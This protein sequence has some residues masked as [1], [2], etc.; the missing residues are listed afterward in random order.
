M[1]VEKD[2]V[3]AGAVPAVYDAYLVP[4]IFQSYAIDTAKRLSEHP[5]ASVLEI[6]CGTGVLTRA[7]A[8]TLP[9]TSRIIASDLNQ[10]MLDHAQSR[11]S[12]ENIDW[13]Q[14]DGMK[15]P[16]GD[17]EFDAVVCQFTA[18]FFP[19]KPA[20]FG[21][22]HRVLSPGGTYICSV[23]DRIEENEIADAVTDALATVFPDD[24]P[25]FMART[26]HGYHDLDVI[27]SDLARAG[28]SDAQIETIAYRSRADSPRDAAIAYCHGSPLRDE[29]IARNPSGL[30]EATNA[31]EQ[32]VA[33]RFGTGA[34]DAKM[35]AHIITVQK[36]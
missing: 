7:L 18:M 2:T 13:R 28:I 10:P 25:R 17:G 1:T 30:N 31:A 15:L 6:G 34:V 3:F 14:A 33:A 8:S 35:Q 29:I 21:E 11:L 4:L 19:D 24:P 23:W 5:P 26:P 12:A 9:S 20:A 27:R 16:F 22:A 36:S 32:A